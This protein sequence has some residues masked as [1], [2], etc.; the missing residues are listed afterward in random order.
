MM[1]IRRTRGERSPR[2]KLTQAK[3]KLI[4]KDTRSQQEIAD[5]FGVKRATIGAIKRR[6]LWSHVK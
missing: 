1:P 2:A 5:A 3:V 4:R 6:D